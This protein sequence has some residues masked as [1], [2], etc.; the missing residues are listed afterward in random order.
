MAIDTGRCPA[1]R[2]LWRRF[3]FGWLFL[4]LIATGY[5]LAIASYLFVGAVDPYALR[6]WGVKARL[7]DRPYDGEVTPLIMMTAANDGTDLVVVGGSTSLGYMPAMLR[8]AFPDAHQPVNMSFDGVNADDLSTELDAFGRSPTIR[9]LILNLDWPLIKDRADYGHIAGKPPYDG[10]W[11]NPVPEYNP[12]SMEMSVRVLRTGLLASPHWLDPSEELPDTVLADRPLTDFPDQLAHIAHDVAVT[13]G[14]LTR[15]Q[16][17]P[18][19]AMPK[20]AHVMAQLRAIAA[21]GVAIDIIVPPYS[22]YMYPNWSD[23]PPQLGASFH[24][25]QAFAQMMSLRRCALEET[26]GVANIRIHAFDTDTAI[27]GNLALYRDT[28]HLFD[29]GTYRQILMHVAKGDSVLTLQAWP[30][31]EAKLRDEVEELPPPAP[32]A[33]TPAAPQ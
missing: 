11:Y 9:R 8:Q 20:L 2:R 4:P 24:H 7:V 29:P 31:F 14:W 21:R 1:L 6:P 26:A 33:T 23:I 3:S 15:G 28:S 16:E 5:A 19:S 13:R 25:D 17:L 12:E 27:T 22:L 30:S 32:N 18:C 10:A